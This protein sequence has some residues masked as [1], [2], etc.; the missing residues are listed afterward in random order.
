MTINQIK[1]FAIGFFILPL[2]AIAAFN[3]N[4]ASAVAKSFHIVSNSDGAEA[5]ATYKAKCAACHSPKAE[6]SFDPAKKDDELIEIVLKGKKAAKPPH[7]PEFESKG[8]TKEKAGDL[9]GY[10]KKLRKPTAETDNKNAK[11]EAKEETDEKAR[12]AL[13][14]FY[15]TNCA[16][17]H[18]AKAEKFY[19][20]ETKGDERVRIILKGK[21]GEKP[22]YMPAFEVKGV[23]EKQA[24]AL[25]AYMIEL[26]TPGK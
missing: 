15:K 20:P 9:V 23:T 18:S 19:N 1:L 26:R 2:L 16:A 10:M 11:A 25:D 21:K 7:M 4:N 5:A 13:V 17:C 8:I 6:K 3:T 14:A 24:K 12:E 22:P